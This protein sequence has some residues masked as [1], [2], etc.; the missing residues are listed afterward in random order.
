[1]ERIERMGTVSAF[2]AMLLVAGC[3]VDMSQDLSLT[4]FNKAPDSV[5]VTGANRTTTCTMTIPDGTGGAGGQNAVRYASCKF[6]SPSGKKTADCLARSASGDDWSCDVTIPAQ[7]EDGTW[8]I[9]TIF[10]EDEAGNKLFATGA[11]LV[12]D[13]ENVLGGDATRVDLEVTSDFAD[14]AGPSITD[15]RVSPP[16]VIP[17]NGHGRGKRCLSN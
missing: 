1:M 6:V 13:A 9:D 14:V 16:N 15:F 4:E 7:S 12:A 11:E 5:D 17:G 8:T 3:A 2:A 10:V